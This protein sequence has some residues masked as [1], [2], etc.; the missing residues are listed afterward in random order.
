VLARAVQEG[1]QQRRLDRRLDLRAREAVGRPGELLQV[2][3]L[4]V[5]APLGEVG[6]EDVGAVLGRQ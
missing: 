6:P 4:R 3:R 2:E 5:A 1:V